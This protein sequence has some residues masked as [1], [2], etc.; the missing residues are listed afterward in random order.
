MKRNIRNIIYNNAFVS[1]LHGAIVIFLLLFYINN[2]VE[3]E[4]TRLEL[5][6]TTSIISPCS[7]HHTMPQTFFTIFS[8][9]VELRLTTE[10][11]DYRLVNI[12]EQNISMISVA[13]ACSGEPLR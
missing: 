4:Q 1:V 12:C 13:Q 9:A 11:N 7:T 2:G 8:R 6:P 5:A 10:L 3:G